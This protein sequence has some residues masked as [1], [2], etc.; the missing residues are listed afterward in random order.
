MTT[1]KYAVSAY[2]ADGVTTDYLITWDYLDEDHIT[3]YVDGTSNGDPQANHTFTKLNNTTLRIT[4]GVGDAIVSGSEIEIRRETPLLTRAITFADGSALLA[5]DLN[6][7]SDYLLY[8]MQEVLDTVDAAA[9]DGALAAQTTTEELRDETLVLKNT[10]SGYLT[11]AQAN[12][13]AALVSEDA[14]EASQVAALASQTAAATSETNAATSETAAATSAGESATSAAEGLTSANNAATSETNAATS[15][16]NAAASAAAGLAS[17]NAASASQTAAATSETNAEAAWDSFDDRYLGAKATAPE[18]DNDGDAILD[19][20]LYWNTTDNRMYL[21]STD[22]WAFTQSGLATVATSG[23]YNDLI[24]IPPATASSIVLYEADP[25]DATE[26]D[27]YYNTVEDTFR[28]FNG[29]AWA[30]VSNQAPASTAGVRDLGTVSE[31]D[32]LS[33]DLADDFEDDATDDVDLTFILASGSL[34]SGATMPT[35][36]STTITGTAPTVASATT[37]TFG[38]KVEDENGAQST[39]KSYT[40]EVE[41]LPVGEAVFTS[42]GNSSWVAPAG[43]STVSVVAVGAGG[44]SSQT[45]SGGGGG[46]GGALAWKNNISVTAGTSYTITVGQGGTPSTGDGGSGGS[47]SAF[48]V[49]ANGGSGGK[50]NAG[51]ASGGT[52]SGADGGGNG[53]AGIYQTTTDGGGGGGAGGYTGNGGNGANGTA[54]SS[55]GSAGSGGGGGG[56]GSTESSISGGGGGGVGLNGQGPSGGGGA[57]ERGGGGGSGGAAGTT[58]GGAYGGG[59][60]GSDAALVNSRG[61]GGNGAV[62]IIWGPSRS[63]PNNAT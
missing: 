48:G 36:G 24:N 52:F 4:D 57:T 61:R 55:V 42:V 22:A 12:A 29:T 43:V 19:G 49:V 58:N 18:L 38:I 7:N 14:A 26:G 45:S 2:T 59:G 5:E 13:A 25:T 53:G 60:P 17:Q 10:T 1:V 21:W 31:L 11:L 9:Q 16:T 34:P 44:G 47:S 28:L 56:G 46:A 27:I 30:N 62:R 41:P 23:D 37:F 15:E 6:K 63:F 33:I 54:P 39:V 35:G 40:I 8:S 3:V 51:T 50:G 32:S 20:A